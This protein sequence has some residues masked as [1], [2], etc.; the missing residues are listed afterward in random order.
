MK[1]WETK[2]GYRIIQLLSG[3]SNVF[4]LTGKN[5]NILI[6]TGPKGGWRRL[7]R[8][9]QAFN[10]NRLDGLILTHAHYDHAENACRLKNEYR[11]RVFV[12]R[13]EEL[14]LKSGTNVMISGTNPFT[15]LMIRL[16]A[17]G[18]QR[19][20]RYQPCQ[21]DVL[22]DSFYNLKSLGFHATVI[23]TPGHSPGS[24]SV[25]VDDEIALVG[26][27]M[28]G[29]IPGGAFPP[30]AADAKQLVASWAILLKTGCRLFLPA[31]GGPRTREQLQ[32][33]YEE[34][35]AGRQAEPDSDF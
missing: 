4:L 14:F 8:R 17:G 34:R 23:H 24:M 3:R 16:L 12:H 27:A 11:A 35:S 7:N 32:R 33:E 20:A 13:S 19:L 5:K 28:Y 26:D 2:S 18:F 31:H 15:G 30:F 9:L 29:V 25:I 22:V 10:V 6:D 1:V 21:A